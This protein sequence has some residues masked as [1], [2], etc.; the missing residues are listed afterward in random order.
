MPLRKGSGEV[1]L[2]VE[3]E[4]SELQSAEVLELEPEGGGLYR[5]QSAEVLVLELEGGG[6]GGGAEVVCG[7]GEAGGTY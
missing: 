6:G 2:V 7:V 3:A 4:L 1:V 5:R